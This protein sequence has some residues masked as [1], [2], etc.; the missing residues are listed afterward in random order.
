LTRILLVRHGETAWNAE[1]RVQGRTDTPLS[2]KGRAQAA[3]LAERLKSVTL[4]AVYSSDLSRARE[5]AE[6]LAAPHGSLPVLP[7]ARL[8]ERGYGDW[9]GLTLTEIAAR[10]PKEWDQYHYQRLL[11]APVPDGEAWEQV[12]ARFL[13]ALRQI[14]Q[15][16]SG[17]DE[18]VLLVGHGGSLRAAILDALAAPLPVLVRLRLDNASLSRLDYTKSNYGRVIFLNDTSHLEGAL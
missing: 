16:H 3:S 15:D 9:E 18:T 17:P 8:R 1:G 5:T 12:I 6:T 14:V 4:A 13:P 11:D 7:D 10:Y 2:D